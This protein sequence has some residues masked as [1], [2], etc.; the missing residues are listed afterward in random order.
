MPFFIIFSYII[1]HIYE[2]GKVRDIKTLSGGETFKAALSLS[3]GMADMMSQQSGNIVLDTLFIDEGFGSLDEK[4]LDSA[5]DTLV[6][7]RKSGKVI[8]IISHVQELKERIE[9]KILVTH[10]SD[11]SEATIAIE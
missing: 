3:L 10:T 9:A 5:I 4:S 7:L 2:S 1:F 6:D 11:G 8:G